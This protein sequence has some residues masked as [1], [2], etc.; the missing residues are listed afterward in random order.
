[1]PDQATSA[2]GSPARDAEVPGFLAALGVPGIVDLHVHFMPESVLRKV[3]AYFD[4]M[5]ATDGR[6]WPIRYRSDEVAR[7]GT[8]RSLGVRAFPTLVYPHKAGMADWLNGWALPWA[9]DVEGALP[10]ATFFPEPTAASYVA[11]ALEAGARIFKAHVQV[12]GYD[13]RDPLLDPVWGQLADA[14]VPVVV[15][16]GSGPM[17]GPFTGPGPIAAVLARHPGLRMVV[18]HMGLPEYEEFLDLA[19]RYPGV[20][21]DTTMAFTAFTES[22]APFPTALL[23]QVRDLG[24]AGSIVFGS[25][26]PNIPYAYAHQVKSLARLGLGADWLRAVLWDNGA[27]MIGLS[28]L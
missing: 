9:A 6:G 15:H 10:T 2:F 14:G 7:L 26:F 17:P 24:L 19:S 20:S 3:W 4:A 13:P 25:D 5:G 23:P 28:S 27:R 21:L 16:C 22:I 1:M 11:A 8:L 12:G 18:A